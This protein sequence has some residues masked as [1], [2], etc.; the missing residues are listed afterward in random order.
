[1]KVY[2]FIVLILVSKAVDAQVSVKDEPNH[3]V[4]FENQ[5]VRILDVRL[6]P[7]DTTLY[8]MHQTPSV[9]LCYSK[10]RMGNQEQG[11]EQ[12]QSESQKGSAWY[13]SF[14]KTVQIHRVW[15][16]DSVPFHTVDIEILASKTGIAVKR[17]EKANLELIA[18]EERVRIYKIELLP[19]SIF[20]LKSNPTQFILSPVEGKIEVSILRGR[21]NKLKGGECLW[22]DRNQS[23]KVTNISNIKVFGYLFEIKP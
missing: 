4:V 3:A 23:F 8:H 14:A 19:K 15:N 2:F 11:K 13:R 9:F 17:I 18:D 6:K 1:M 22:I 5:Y 20:Q 16:R 7:G 10:T 12:T 21:K